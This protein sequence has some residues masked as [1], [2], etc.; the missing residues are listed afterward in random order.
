L[1]NYYDETLEEFYKEYPEYR[2]EINIQPM[3]LAVSKECA[4][5]I[6]DWAKDGSENK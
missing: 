2:L 5:D 1:A 6:E 4:E 3:S